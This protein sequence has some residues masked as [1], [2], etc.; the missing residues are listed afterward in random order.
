MSSSVIILR[1]ESLTCPITI[2]LGSILSAPDGGSVKKGESIAKWDPYNVPILSEFAGKVDFRDFIVGVT[3]RKE[4]DEATGMEDIV[5]LEHRDEIHPQVLV[6][7][8]KDRKNILASYTIPAGA[9][10]VLDKDEEIYAG[11]VIAKTPRKQARTK[12]ITGGLPRVSELF[13]ARMHC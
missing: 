1:S 11:A 4:V 10:V 2:Q 13:E 5:V 6:R 7:D 9:H 12:D 3:V 8:P